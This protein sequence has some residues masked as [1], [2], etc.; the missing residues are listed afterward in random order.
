MPAI[1]YLIK[2]REQMSRKR[3]RIEFGFFVLLMT[4]AFVWAFVG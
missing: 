3:I 2:D 1:N 4:L